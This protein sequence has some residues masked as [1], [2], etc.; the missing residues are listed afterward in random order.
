MLCGWKEENL[1]SHDTMEK[2]Y[3]M[4]QIWVPLKSVCLKR[5]LELLEWKNIFLKELF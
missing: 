5:F 4:V 3:D 2:R 1:G